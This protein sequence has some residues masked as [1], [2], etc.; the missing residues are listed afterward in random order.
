MKS[1]N[2][3]ETTSKRA[4]R[5]M[6][7]SWGVSEEIGKN[8]RLLEF[9]GL[10]GIKHLNHYYKDKNFKNFENIR[11]IDQDNQSTKFPF[12]P[13]NLGV[14]F[15][16]QIRSLEISNNYTFKGIVYPI[17]FLPFLSRASEVIGKKILFNF[18]ENHF[19]MSFNINISSNFF[20]GKFP[21]LAQSAQVNF[22]D[23]KDNFND[24]EW[25]SL[26]SIS[27][28]TFVEESDSSQKSSAGAGLTDND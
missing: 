16:D 7:Y 1:F 25:K 24:I 6:G 20:K 17:L 18:D 4:S 28:E 10:P 26:Y 13:I 12:C 8:I 22:I 19:L 27:E 2:E 11:L 9:F 14:N 15:L 23:N 5:A 21:L 3:I